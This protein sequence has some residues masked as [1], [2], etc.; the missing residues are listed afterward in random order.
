MSYNTF[1]VFLIPTTK[2]LRWKDRIDITEYDKKMVRGLH[3]VSSPN[4]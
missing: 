4:H 3:L 2:A 1:L